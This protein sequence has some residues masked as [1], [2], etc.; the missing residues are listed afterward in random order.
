MVNPRF[1]FGAGLRWDYEEMGCYAL[2]ILRDQTGVFWWIP[3]VAGFA[4]NLFGSALTGSK[5][6]RA[7][8]HARERSQALAIQQVR[9]QEVDDIEKLKQMKELEQLRLE[10]VKASSFQKGSYTGPFFQVVKK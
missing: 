5:G 10:T 6:K 7:E 4:L 9:T 8:R 2:R 1:T 3:L